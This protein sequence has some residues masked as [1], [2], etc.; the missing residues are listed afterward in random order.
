VTPSV[1]RLE[2]KI[3]N[4]EAAV[5][6]LRQELESLKSGDNDD[7]R[8]VRLLRL[9]EDAG[10][11]VSSD[12]WRRLGAQC[13]YDPRGLGGFFR[14]GN[15]SMYVDGDDRVLSDRGGYDLDDHLRRTDEDS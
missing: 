8:W 7:Q 10:G 12:E 6:Q 5:A 4:V 3:R 2:Q 14:G 9:V 1:S 15:P 13:G 11:R